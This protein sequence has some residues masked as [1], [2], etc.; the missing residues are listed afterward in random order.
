M[1]LVEYYHD[2]D[3]KTG[4]SY[5]SDSHESVEDGAQDILCNDSQ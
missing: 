2:F 5:K 3:H 4:R 1:S